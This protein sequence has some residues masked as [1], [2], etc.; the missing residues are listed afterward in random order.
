MATGPVKKIIG[1]TLIAS[2]CASFAACKKEP[3]VTETSES[4]S[5]ATTSATTTP[6][7]TETTEETEPAP[8][9]TKE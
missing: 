2:I 1:I 3:V 9:F 6:T 4:T 5:E 8:D 7:T